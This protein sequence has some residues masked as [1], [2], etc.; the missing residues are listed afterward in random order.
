M[1][2][3]ITKLKLELKS[4]KVIISDGAKINP[5]FKY[6][7]FKHPEYLQKIV[8]ATCFL[9]YDAPIKTRIQCIIKNIDYQPLCKLCNSPCK[10]ITSGSK[11]N[12]Q[13]SSYCSRRCSGLDLL[14]TNIKKSVD[15]NLTT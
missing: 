2:T 11:N 10:M 5:R 13:F 15:P 12:N 9:K 8:E 7:L 14:P 1:L 4:I 6:I 3:P